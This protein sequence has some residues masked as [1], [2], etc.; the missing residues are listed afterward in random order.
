[1]AKGLIKGISPSLMCAD[2]LTLA[3]SV[4][5]LNDLKITWFHIDVMDGHFVPNFGMNLNFIRDLR[6][7]TD[8]LIEVHLMCSDPLA[9]IGKVLDLGA[10]AVSFH[11]E[12]TH[13]PVRCLELIKSYG[14][15]A[16]IPLSP[17][18]S[19]DHLEYCL[20]HLD[21]IT[22]MGVE[23][24]FEGQRFLT[25]T[26]HKTEQM[27]HLITYHQLDVM[28]QIDGGV[29]NSIGRELVERGADIL[30][31]GVPTI[32]K[33]DNLKENYAAMVSIFS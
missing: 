4:N 28:I 22:L 23:P 1:M 8:K 25:Q 18:T 24:G 12:A 26:Y 6:A 14:S 15:S 32:F 29:D 20:E 13:A 30:V 31:G 3:H 33:D 16:G 19:P 17:G 27:K 5:I 10:D 7:A 2:S 9:W 21:Y 11:M